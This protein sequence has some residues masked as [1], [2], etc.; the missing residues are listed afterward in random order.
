MRQITN[1]PKLRATKLA[2]GKNR[3]HKKVNPEFEEY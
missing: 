1:N 3:L 2:S